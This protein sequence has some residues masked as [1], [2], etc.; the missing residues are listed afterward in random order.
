MAVTYSK[1]ALP[2]LA[3]PVLGTG[4]VTLSWTGDNGGPYI[5]G[6]VGPVPGATSGFGVQHASSIAGP[7]TTTFA[8]GNSITL[9]A[10]GSMGFYR[11]VAPISG[12]TTLCAIPVTLQ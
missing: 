7:W 9:P 1:W 5:D 6:P 3:T 10:T 8:P 2:V 11:I 12:L 4:T